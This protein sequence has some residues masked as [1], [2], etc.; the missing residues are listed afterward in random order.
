MTDAMA[1]DRAAFD[2]VAEHTT[3]D[4]TDTPPGPPG[5]ASG[6]GRSSRRLRT[7]R[8]G[9]S[10]WA[11]A[12]ARTRSGSGSAGRVS[13]GH[14][15]FARHAAH[16]AA[17]KLA[18]RGLDGPRPASSGRSTLAPT[19]AQ[20]RHQTSLRRRVLPTSACSTASP[21]GASSRPWS[22]RSVRPGGTLVT[23]VMGPFCPWETPA[24]SAR[25]DLRPRHA[26]RPRAARRHRRRGARCRSGIRRRARSRATFGP[27]FTRPLVSTAG[28]APAAVLPR[29]PGRPRPERVRGGWRE[30]TAT[31]RCRAWW[32]DHYLT[33]FEKRR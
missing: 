23:V 5:C 33:V 30:S 20:H 24:I 4:F 28:H 29:A 26:A 27:H 12:P 14:R 21:T 9:C 1:A 17:A 6:C 18:R 32:A 22:G 2:E 15:R 19:S 8:S 25:G 10:S 31:C 11:A 16:V 7:G 3:T 13:A